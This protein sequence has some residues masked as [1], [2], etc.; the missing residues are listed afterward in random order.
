VQ[1]LDQARNLRIIKDTKGAKVAE[2]RSKFWDDLEEDLKDPEFAREFFKDGL[3]ITFI[4]QLINDLDE[5][6]IELG[7][8]K[9]KLA[10]TLG[11]EPANVRR[12]FS[13]GPKNPTL[14]TM[15]DI[16]FGLGMKLQLVPL[17]EEDTTVVIPP[18]V[19]LNTLH[20]IDESRDKPEAK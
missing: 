11:V 15:V 16:A 13:R 3:Y 20:P 5:K 14:T 17:T 9:A 2:F 18:P 10:E 4:D 12:L 7:L 19:Q 8:S 6:R 1:N